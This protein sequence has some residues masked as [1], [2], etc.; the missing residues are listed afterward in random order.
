MKRA[1]RN[2]LPVPDTWQRTTSTE[3]LTWLAGWPAESY[4][5]LLTKM[6]LK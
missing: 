1:C 5:R 2:S 4:Q 6:R 3:F